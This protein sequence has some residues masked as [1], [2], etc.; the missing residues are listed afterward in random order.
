MSPD[1]TSTHYVTQI[2]LKLK[3]VILFSFPS[4][5]MI[6]VSHNSQLGR[7]LSL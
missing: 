5:G 7:Y 3:S 4:A 1:Y 6:G 2:G